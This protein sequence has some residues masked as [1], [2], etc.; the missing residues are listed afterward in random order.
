M[1]P[2]DEIWRYPYAPEFP[3]RPLLETV[4]KIAGRLL[5]PGLVRLETL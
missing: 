5:N 1:M 4:W 3:R 2:P